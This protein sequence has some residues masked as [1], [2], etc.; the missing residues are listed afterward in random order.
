MSG[1]SRLDEFVGYRYAKSVAAALPRII[2][3]VPSDEAEARELK[4]N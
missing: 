2:I 3:V 1:V 4:W